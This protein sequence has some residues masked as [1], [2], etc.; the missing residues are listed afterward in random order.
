M[1]QEKIIKLTED[2]LKEAKDEH[3][4]RYKVLRDLKELKG[5]KG[6]VVRL[7]VSNVLQ[8]ALILLIIG[9]LVYLGR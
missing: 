7:E 6:R 9:A 1:A 8:G 3:L 4:F 5:V 2:E